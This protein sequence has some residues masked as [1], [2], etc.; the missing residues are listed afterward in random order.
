MTE[1]SANTFGEDL[2][3]NRIEALTD[4]IFAIAMTLL[5]LAIDFPQEGMKGTPGAVKQLLFGQDK[6][7][8]NYALSFMLLASFWTLHHQLFRFLKKTDAVHLWINIIKLM[9]IAMVPFS[10][11]LVGDFPDDKTSQLIFGANMFIIGALFLWNW[12]YAG[13]KHRL[14]DGRMAVSRIRDL[15]GEIAIIPVV[16]LGAV[17]VAMFNPR[18]AIY[19]YIIIPLYLILFYG[20]WRH[21]KK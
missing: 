14:V 11:S 20:K 15:A 6:E 2:P 7:F 1:H 13:W 4:G 18:A 8:F 5:V 21:G 16:S 3:I 17:M 10:S 19:V 9:F 12:V